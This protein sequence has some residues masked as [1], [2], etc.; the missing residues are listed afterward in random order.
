MLIFL[1][2]F[3]LLSVVVLFFFLFV[4]PIFL[5][6]LL[7]LIGGGICNLLRSL[8]LWVDLAGDRWY[9]LPGQRGLLLEGGRLDTW[10][11]LTWEAW[12]WQAPDLRGS[13]WGSEDWG[14]RVS[15]LRRVLWY[16]WCYHIMR[17]RLLLLR[18]L[19]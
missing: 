6:L 11:C 12:R 7:L 3:S 17:S 8:H 1:F 5:T 15:Q 18:K 19:S 4:L 10:Q 9:G 14:W 16:G 2:L 13:D